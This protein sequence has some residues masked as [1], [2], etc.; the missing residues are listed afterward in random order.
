MKIRV[1]ERMR[2]VSRVKEEIIF[3]V[4]LP[5]PGLEH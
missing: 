2:G 4:M 5:S 1:G 3:E